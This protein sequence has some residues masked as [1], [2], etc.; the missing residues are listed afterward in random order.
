MSLAIHNEFQRL[1]YG[2]YCMRV[3]CFHES[4]RTSV[5]VLERLSRLKTEHRSA[6]PEDGF[7]AV[8]SWLVQGAGGEDDVCEQGH[9]YI[10]IYMIHS[11]YG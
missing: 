2:S 4:M 7:W 5:V 9:I 3:E 6:R 10:Y 11:K 8:P 1:M